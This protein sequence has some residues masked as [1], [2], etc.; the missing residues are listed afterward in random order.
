MEGAAIS[1]DDEPMR[2]L[3]PVAAA[4]ASNIKS[5]PNG[6]KPADRNRS[7]MLIFYILRMK[8]F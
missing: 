1:D 5:Q 3:E 7:D 4:A 6:Y 8:I 2:M